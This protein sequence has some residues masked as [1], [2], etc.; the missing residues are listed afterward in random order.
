MHLFKFPSIKKE[1]DNRS[2]NEGKDK[3]RVMRVEHV[4][5][6]EAFA[7]D[8]FHLYSLKANVFSPTTDPKSKPRNNP[9]SACQKEE[10]KS[11]K[12]SVVKV[13]T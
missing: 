3:T 9:G 7:F 10:K 8:T 13:R 11:L 4:K 5:R 2:R 1:V 6:K 12:P